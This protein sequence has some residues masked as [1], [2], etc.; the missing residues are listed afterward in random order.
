MVIRPKHSRQHIDEDRVQL[1]AGY[2]LKS[3][4]MCG[5]Y[6][7]A[8]TH[9]DY[10]GTACMAN[11]VGQIGHVIFQELKIP[12]IAVKAVHARAGRAV[13]GHQPLLYDG[14]GRLGRRPPHRWSAGIARTYVDARKRIPTHEFRHTGFPGARDHGLELILYDRKLEPVGLDRSVTQCKQGQG[15]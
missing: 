6:V 5:E 9:A 13:D 11:V 10:G 12:E 1:D 7:S 14:R 3:E 2:I 15:C 8:T 4:E